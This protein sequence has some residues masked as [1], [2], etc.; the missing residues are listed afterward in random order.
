MHQTTPVVDAPTQQQLLHKVTLAVKIAIA[1]LFIASATP[2][3]IQLLVCAHK[4]QQVFLAPLII[5]APRKIVISEM[6][7]VYARV[8]M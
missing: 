7:S 3:G 8:W 6:V 5:N 4:H 2:L 1:F